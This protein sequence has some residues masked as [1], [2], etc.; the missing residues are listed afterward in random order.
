[1]TFAPPQGPAQ[2]A[3]LDDGMFLVSPG[4]PP[5]RMVCTEV[6]GG[7]A[8]LVADR[9]G[10]YGDGYGLLVRVIDG[11]PLAMYHVNG[12]PFVHPDDI[13][14]VYTRPLS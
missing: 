3:G 11:H 1:M 7:S 4:S 14:T 10:V 12:V 6:S 2:S 5:I 9:P 8:T 13:V